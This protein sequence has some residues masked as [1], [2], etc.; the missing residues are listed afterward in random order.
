M[1][2][3]EAVNTIYSDA[4]AGHRRRSGWSAYIGLRR[5]LDT[6]FARRDDPQYKRALD[7]LL[8]AWQEGV[9]PHE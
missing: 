5:R 7:R 2:T 3:G 8:A 1:S 6:L 4:A 9:V